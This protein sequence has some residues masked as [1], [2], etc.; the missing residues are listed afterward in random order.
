MNVPFTSGILIG[1]GETRR[2]RIEALLALRDLHETHGH[3]QEIIIQPFRAKP[4]TLMADVADAPLEEL[5][6]TCAVARLIMGPRVNIQTPPNLAPGALSKLI[7]AGINDW[8]GI[9]PVTPDHV[10]PEA[11]W[12]HLAALGEQTMAAGKVLVERLGIYPDYIA[13]EKKWLDDGFHTHVKHAVDAH[14][15]VRMDAWSPG[16]AKTLPASDARLAISG[17]KQSRDKHI[18]GIVDRAMAGITPS[19]TEIT[20]LFSARG[21]DFAAV[22]TA[23]DELRYDL[24]GDEVSYVVTRNINYTNI[25]SFKC[26]FCAFSKGKLSE[27]L[28]GRP[29]NL[30]IDE[31]VRR[32]DEA[33]ARGASELCMQGGIHPAYTGETYLKICRA[34]KAQHPDLHIHA[35]SPLE[36]SQGAETLGLSVSG[37]LS[38][39]MDEGL[40]SLPGTAAEILDDEVRAVICHDKINTQEWLDVMAAAHALGLRSTATIM[41]GHVEQ[42]VHW[43]R[44]LLRILNL[45]RHTGGFTEFVPLPFVHME[46][47]IYLKGRA[48]RGPTFRECVLM[49]AVAR[50]VFHETLPNIQASWV[51]MGEDGV[52]HCL[53]AGANDAGGTLMNETITR[54]AGAEH[55]QEMAPERMEALIASINRVPRQRT[56]LYGTPPTERIVASFNAPILSEKREKNVAHGKMPVNH[57]TRIITPGSAR[58]MM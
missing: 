23:A 6:W 37:F 48:R 12:P 4:D 51:K 18:S 46:T 54:S 16:A 40:A 44:H 57:D 53:Q 11:P 49:H 9:S 19:E 26:Q 45:Q 47:P 7:K 13:H 14:G 24:V 20:R 22:C 34:L 2:E 5:L 32:A 31:I 42:P 15:F 38:K 39:L 1:I 52:K 8:G 43:A 17:Q 50:L 3:I 27:N 56:T 30:E 58:A 41:F 33:W 28:R 29:Y 25:C 36:I 21:A 10:N 55:G 35:F